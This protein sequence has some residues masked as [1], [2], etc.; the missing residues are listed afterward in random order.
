MILGQEPLGWRRDNQFNPY[1]EGTGQSSRGR[2]FRGRGERGWDDLSR[3][4][5]QR[6]HSSQ[7]GWSRGRGEGGR[8]RG[9]RGP[10]QREYRDNRSYTLSSQTAQPVWPT[11]G[12][13]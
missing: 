7:R 6:A 4:S 8:G 1:H 10:P 11:Q 5:N 9:E 13:Y 2:G 12:K 3:G